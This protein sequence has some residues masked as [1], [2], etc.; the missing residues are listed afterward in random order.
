MA[1]TVM[2]MRMLSAFVSLIECA[3]AALNGWDA[4]RDDR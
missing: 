3:L 2:W 1:P 4:P